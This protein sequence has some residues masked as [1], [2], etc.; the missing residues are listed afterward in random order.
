MPGQLLHRHLAFGVGQQIVRR[1][2]GQGHLSPGKARRS[3]LGL[4]GHLQSAEEQQQLQDLHLQI[5]PAQVLRH[6]IQL[7]K[8]VLHP[9]GGPGGKIPPG[10][11]E[12]FRQGGGLHLHVL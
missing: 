7:R 2:S 11:A 12:F 6:L 4:G 5:P 1:L 9:P 8:H 10:G 3:R